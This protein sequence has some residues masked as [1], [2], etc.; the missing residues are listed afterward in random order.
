MQA[1]AISGCRRQ[2]HLYRST[3]SQLHVC[4][5]EERSPDDSREKRDNGNMV[6]HGPHPENGV[7]HSTSKGPPGN[8]RA[9]KTTRELAHIERVKAQRQQHAARNYK[10]KT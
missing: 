9:P 1:S 2:P 7:F 5:L 8:H 4:L 6:Q 10:M 3:P